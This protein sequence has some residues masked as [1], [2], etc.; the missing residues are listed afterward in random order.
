MNKQKINLRNIVVAV[1]L[2][3]LGGAYF[4]KANADVTP[5][6]FDLL[7]QYLNNNID[8][9]GA[10]TDGIITLGSDIPFTINSRI[11]FGSSKTVDGGGNR[12]L[13][14]SG[15]SAGDPVMSWANNTSKYTAKF[16][17]ITLDIGN[18]LATVFSVGANKTL[19]LE[20]TT[21]T[22]TGNTNSVINGGGGEFFCL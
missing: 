9:S 3:T 20:N 17:N 12:S 2:L 22:A 6:T 19:S 21:M 18:N 14:I 5:T 10:G 15:Y 7:Q 11:V 1:T 8:Y 4:H 13:T 16:Q